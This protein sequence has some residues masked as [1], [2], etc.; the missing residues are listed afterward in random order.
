MEEYVD[1]KVY[2][3]TGLRERISF[4][5]W[6]KD[7]RKVDGTWQVV[8]EKEGRGEVVYHAKKVVIATGTSSVPNLPDLLGKKSFKGPILHQKD[9]GRSNLLTKD[10]ENIEEHESITIYGGAKSAAD[11]AYAAAK[12]TSRDGK[13]RK[14]NWIVRS[15]GKGALGYVHPK[16]PFSKYRNITETATTR[17]MPG[18]SSANPYLPEGTWREWLL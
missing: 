2:A 13:H 1:G 8:A 6:V 9:I 16:S 14:V 11:L 17:A 3:G 18:L 7:V 4:S 5:T 10:E 12:D 15:S